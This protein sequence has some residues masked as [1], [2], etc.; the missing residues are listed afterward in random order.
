MARTAT[1]TLK[2]RS[3]MKPGLQKAKRE[4][5]FFVR[6]QKQ[7]FGS[8][9]GVASGA[10]FGGVAAAGGAAAAGLVGFGLSV[11]NTADK[12][13]NMSAST[14]LSTDAIQ[15]WGHM[16]ERAG[17]DADSI[18]RAMVQLNKQIENA[19]RGS[20]EAADSVEALGFSWQELSALPADERLEMVARALIDVESETER[21]KVATDLFG[22]SS[23]LS[24]RCVGHHPGRSSRR[25]PLGLPS[26][27]SN[28]PRLRW[29]QLDRAMRRRGLI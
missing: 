27:G 13:D 2:A 15:T 3:N 14:G 7:L 25:R 4:T 28:C 24:Y 23:D 12:L 22:R 8:L 11:L 9:G 20:K 10:L 17:G 26:W 1:V 5:A 16:I 18:E 29:Q 21:T 6:G 19:A